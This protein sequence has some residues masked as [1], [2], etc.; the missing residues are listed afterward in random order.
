MR[1]DGDVV[2]M[3]RGEAVLM[4]VNDP[5][6]TI[7]PTTDPDA[8]IRTDAGAM[9]LAGFMQNYVQFLGPV[10]D[11][12]RL[13]LQPL[14]EDYQEQALRLVIALTPEDRREEAART[15]APL[16]NKFN[17]RRASRRT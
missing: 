7:D 6:I 2:Y 1:E 12:E 17:L 10:I 5:D 16:L 13:D 8:S 9:K 3:K 14:W 4:L 15:F 11:K